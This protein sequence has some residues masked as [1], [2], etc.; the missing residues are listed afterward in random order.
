MKE[1]DFIAEKGNWKIHIQV[2]HLLSSQK[3][4]ER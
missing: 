3:I 2:A 4:I 1:I